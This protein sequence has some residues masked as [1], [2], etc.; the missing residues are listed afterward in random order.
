MEAVQ[1]L[2]C[3]PHVACWEQLDPNTAPELQ[4]DLGSPPW[5]DAVLT[6]LRDQ[7][8][9]GCLLCSL[10]EWNEEDRDHA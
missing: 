1:L 4:D 9:A 8:K 7:A 6:Q 10:D 2:A 3:P 5:D